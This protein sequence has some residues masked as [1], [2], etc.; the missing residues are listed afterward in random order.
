MFKVQGFKGFPP[1]I[2]GNYH[3][4]SWAPGDGSKYYDYYYYVPIIAV[5]TNI[6]HITIMNVITII[7][8]N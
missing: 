1:P 5:I 6:I 3:M 4:C 8:F 7:I 2:L